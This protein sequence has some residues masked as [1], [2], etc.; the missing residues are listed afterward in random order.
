[1]LTKMSALKTRIE[2]VGK[3]DG[4]FQMVNQDGMQ[5]K[6]EWNALETRA[7]FFF[8]QNGNALH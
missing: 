8:N 7:E 1:M 4:L 5:I 6:P 3:Q 2:C